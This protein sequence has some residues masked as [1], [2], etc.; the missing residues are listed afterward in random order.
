[1]SLLVKERMNY[2]RNGELASKNIEKNRTSKRW[3]TMF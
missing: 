2:G 1:M 3:S